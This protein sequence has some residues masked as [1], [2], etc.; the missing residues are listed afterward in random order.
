MHDLQQLTDLFKEVRC[1]L[2]P[3]WFKQLEFV[4]RLGSYPESPAQHKQLSKLG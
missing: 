1:G 3:V 2:Q 4:V